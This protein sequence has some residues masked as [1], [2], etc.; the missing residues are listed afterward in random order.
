[1]LRNQFSPAAVALTLLLFC[2]HPLSRADVWGYVDERGVAHFGAERIDERYE[3]Y[4]ATPANENRQGRK[5]FPDTDANVVDSV[6][7]AKLLANTNRS[8]IC[9][10]KR[11]K[12]IR[13]ITNSCRP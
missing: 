4:F 12:S 11:R 2:W 5:P 3:L 1:M 9:C 7:P 13:L 6:P 10:A 8:S